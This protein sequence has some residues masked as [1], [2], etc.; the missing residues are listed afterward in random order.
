L[1][2][3]EQKLE[4]STMRDA[5]LILSLLAIIVSP[6]AA[7]RLIENRYNAD[8]I[9]SGTVV[10]VYSRETKLSRNYVV[11][12]KVEDVE[13]G[14]AVGRGDTFRA[15]CYQRKGGVMDRPFG[16]SAGH[17]TVPMEGQQVKV[18]VKRSGGRNEGVYP[19]WVDVLPQV[20]R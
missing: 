19:D 14:S 9:I 17:K 12:I 10:A 16:D 15:F 3:G 1:F 7:A 11:E 8:Y 6:A 13:K 4:D 5:I 2:G 18:F 20:K